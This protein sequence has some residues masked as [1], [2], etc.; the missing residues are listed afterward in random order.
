M[1]EKD[2]Q[3]N[4]VREKLPREITIGGGAL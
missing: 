4:A 1:P 2:E 3:T